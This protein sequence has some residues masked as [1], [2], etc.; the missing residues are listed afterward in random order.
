MDDANANEDYVAYRK[1]YFFNVDVYKKRIR[2]S[3]ETFL[4]DA[5][6]RA[7]TYGFHRLLFAFKAL[8]YSAGTM[9]YCHFVGLGLG[10]WQVTDKQV[11]WFIEAYASSLYISHSHSI[12]WNKF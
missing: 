2:I 4:F 9:A 8:F 1:G 5:E 12:E 10:V 3:I 11:N 6:D 7:K